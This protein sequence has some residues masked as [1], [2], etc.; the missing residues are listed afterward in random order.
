MGSARERWR[1]PFGH[2][3]P[4]LIYGGRRNFPTFVLQTELLA[5]L[6]LAAAEP[7]SP[8]SGLAA[9]SSRST[10]GGTPSTWKS[11]SVRGCDP[12]TGGDLTWQSLLLR[13]KAILKPAVLGWGSG[14]GFG[15]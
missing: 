13:A 1:R 10:G 5:E 14:Q 8:G 11:R 3:S 6:S 9:S 15:C 2:F 4:N 7:P 12:Y